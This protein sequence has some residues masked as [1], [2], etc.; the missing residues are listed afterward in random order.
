MNV[1]IDKD[2]LAKI[3]NVSQPRVIAPGQQIILQGDEG[4][5]FY[6]ILKGKSEVYIKQTVKKGIIEKHKEQLEN[7]NE[8]SFFGELALIHNVERTASVKSINQSILAV[9]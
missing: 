6:M 2:T 7:L 3:V 8:E 4:F 1:D 5:S 9:I